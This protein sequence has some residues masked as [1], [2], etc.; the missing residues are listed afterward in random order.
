MSGGSVQT[1]DKLFIINQTG[2]GLMARLHMLRTFELPKEI[3]SNTEEVFARMNKVFKDYDKDFDRIRGA[4]V[5]HKKATDIRAHLEDYYLTF[6]DVITWREAALGMLVEVE[7][8]N[9]AFKFKDSGYIMA[10]YMDLWVRYIQLHYLV[11]SVQK[12]RGYLVY[13]VKAHDLHGNSE[14]NFNKLSD[15]IV[16]YDMP[17]LVKKLREDLAPTRGRVGAI[18]Q[19]V[20]QYVMKWQGVEMLQMKETFNIIDKPQNMR[21]ASNE[22]DLIELASLRSFQQWTV[23]GYLFAPECIA[24]AEGMAEMCTTALNI[25]LKD[26]WVVPIFREE[27]L[28]VHEEFKNL[29]GSFTCAWPPNQTKKKFKLNA[30]KFKKPYDVVV[31]DHDGTITDR[32]AF[33]CLLRCEMETL[34]HCFGAFPH[35]IAPKMSMINACLALA[36]WELETYF[37]MTSTPPI[38]AR[39]GWQMKRDPHISSLIHHLQELRKL[40]NETHNDE[41]TGYYRSFLSNAGVVELRQKY[42]DFKRDAP[43]ASQHTHMM[44][45][46]VLEDCQAAEGGEV[47][48]L[49]GLR[50]NCYRL[51][52]V[53]TANTGGANP[54]VASKVG[55]VLTQTIRHARCIDGTKDS[56]LGE[57][58]W[59]PQLLQEVLQTCL[60]PEEYGLPSVGQAQYV[61]SVAAV[62]ADGIDNMRTLCPE[63][64]L[65]IGKK[66]YTLANKF[67][68]A[69]VTAINNRVNKPKLGMFAEL[70][71]LSRLAGPDGVLT[72]MRHQAQNTAAGTDTK[73]PMPGVESLWK[74]RKMGHNKTLNVVKREV[75][76]LVRA[77]ESLDLL[78]VYTYDYCPREYLIEMMSVCIGNS[79]I[80]CLSASSGKHNI[81]RPSMAL[82]SFLEVVCAWQ[83]VAQSSRIDL[84]MIVKQTLAKQFNDD[85][86]GEPGKEFKQNTS[87]EE[88]RQDPAAV[89]RICDWYKAYFRDDLVK[90]GA[91]YSP[92]VRAFVG[93]RDGHSDDS[94]AEIPFGEHT[95]PT[96]LQ[97]LCILMGPQGIRA[98]DRAL[99]SI[100]GENVAIIRDK[101]EKNSVTLNSF[102]GPGTELE[103]WTEIVAKLSEFDEL[104]DAAVRMGCVIKFRQLLRAAMGTVLKHDVPFLQQ[105]VGLTA[106]AIPKINR[107]DPHFTEINRLAA[108]FGLEVGEADMALQYELTKHRGNPGTWNLLPAAFGVIFVAKRWR[109]ATYS[110]RLDGH[111]NNAHMMVDALQALTIYMSKASISDHVQV[112]DRIQKQFEEFVRMASNSL[113]HM[114]GSECVDNPARMWQIRQM[115]V[116]LEKF[117]TSTDRLHLSLLDDC[118]P[119]TL[120]RTNYVALYEAEDSSAAY[121]GI[122]ENEE[123]KE[124]GGQGG[125]RESDNLKP[126]NTSHSQH[127]QS[128]RNLG[129]QQTG[130]K[131]P[132]GTAQF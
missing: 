19:D 26:N 10:E 88:K 109:N 104:M 14:P 100:V 59:W 117:I 107:S 83:H 61:V 21:H 113:L 52:V 11:C 56:S 17:H 65:I 32:A 57:L 118:F 114:M 25:A 16:D 97:S 40:V 4:D 5:Y 103:L 71:R 53:T 110:V 126:S 90:I 84:H 85:S 87:E 50:M 15:F 115:M 30:S 102:Q 94:A 67:M 13:F 2:K 108:D 18:L 47:M 129:S 96:E 45:E 82:S 24:A 105:V 74:F 80:S 33:R 36:R 62:L 75:C 76:Q 66:A 20:Q 6:V 12:R 128:T 106:D 63:E 112:N 81:Q 41:V 38:K 101:L 68:V 132:R 93:V 44:W 35:C 99:L 72:R 98:L 22:S 58:F 46:R 73:H 37:R 3:M 9:R 116:V 131:N 120:L 51:L 7:Q 124:G 49:S 125:A 127:A 31:N 29:F 69:I 39:R 23:F 89:H 122:G 95:D 42:D 64:D 111:T 130:S 8:G 70:T 43:K 54:Q 77:I 27:S 1:A 92:T 86:V 91:A 60:I 119:Y 48:Q 55:P 78:T 34:L 123:Q 79:L 28:N 121:G